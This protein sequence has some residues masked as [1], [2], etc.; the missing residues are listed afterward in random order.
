MGYRKEK[1]DITGKDIISGKYSTEDMINILYICEDKKLNKYQL[2]IKIVYRYII[3][4]IMDG[5]LGFFRLS[6]KEVWYDTVKALENVG[7]SDCAEWIKEFCNL[8]AEKTKDVE[9]FI[10]ICESFDKKFSC[11]YEPDVIIAEIGKYIMK[12]PY[13]MAF[14]GE[15]GILE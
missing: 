6:D 13:N 7:F 11:K 10:G 1:Y 14:S 8:Y 3:R 2:D 5:H 4:V 15:V 12:N 9:Y